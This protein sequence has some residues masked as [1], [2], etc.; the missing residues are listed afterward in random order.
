MTNLSFLEHW[1]WAMD[2]SLEQYHWAPKNLLNKWT[3]QLRNSKLPFRDL[4]ISSRKVLEE[5]ALIQVN[6]Y[7]LYRL[8]VLSCS[9]PNDKARQI[10]SPHPS[11]NIS[12]F[13]KNKLQYL[14]SNSLCFWSYWSQRDWSSKLK[15]WCFQ[16]LIFTK[17]LQLEVIWL[18]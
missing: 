12:R 18:N 16:I 9:P 13:W 17:F 3:R 14:F 5:F 2:Y 11:I 8:T 1:N 4:Q 10:I 7:I 15:E 6:T